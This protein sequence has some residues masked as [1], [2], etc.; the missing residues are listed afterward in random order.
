[1][2]AALLWKELRGLKAFIALI[3]GV[4][5]I[6]FI[7]NLATEIPDAK[8][9]DLD[10]LTVGG[11]IIVLLFFS[12]L[13]GSGLL[14][15]EVSDGT[16]HFLDGLPVSRS[17]IFFAKLAAGF[18]VLC[19]VPVLDLFPD[20]FFGFLSRTSVDPPYPWPFLARFLLL[21][22]FA[23]LSLLCTVSA[24]A[25]LG[26]WF[27]LVA[28]LTFL[29]VLSLL[30][31]GVD[32]VEYL[33]PTA[34]VPKQAGAQ[35]LIPWRHVAAQGGVALVA[36]AIAW[37]RFQNIGAR[38]R[39]AMDSAGPLMRFVLVL[40]R[41]AVPVVWIAVIVLMIRF[42]GPE[43]EESANPGGETAFV[44]DKTSHYE[45]LYR[46]SQRKEIKPLLAYADW[47]FTMVA[48]FFGVPARS[49]R[50]VADLDS[51]IPSHTAGVTNW[52]KIRVRVSPGETEPAF[53][54]VL[55]HE[56]AHV[57]MQEIGGQPF[58]HEGNSTRFFNEGMATAVESRHFDPDLGASLHRFG[59]AA[60]SRGPVPFSSLC[61]DD[62]L[63]KTR[64]PAIAYPLGCAFSEAL[65]RVCGDHAPARVLEEFKRARFNGS[66]K[67]ETLW[68]E[69]FQ[70]CGYSLDAVTA[71]YDAELSRWQTEHADFIARLPAISSSVST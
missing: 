28:G 22:A 6:G 38:S 17:R 50:I 37:L 8:A 61:D 16:L 31:R 43:P 7:Y 45:F 20:A 44:S 30:I 1:M 9:L 23:A 33:K 25:M 60:V 59:A 3:A 39:D 34:L 68:R 53:R 13:L 64:D 51:P 55:G 49:E 35:I 71:A 56:T 14:L 69:I 54:R 70:G 42:S 41:I 47:T 46:G 57:I 29:A 5:L 24:L 52:T 58:V 40:S 36:L 2:M 15:R 26:R 62:E 18:L 11:P 65:I 66:A 12:L 48:D 63:G 32:W 10:K 4:E 21:S 19:M 27:A 67:G